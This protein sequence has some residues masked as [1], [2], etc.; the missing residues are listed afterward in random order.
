MVA[1]P[2]WRLTPPAD[3]GAYSPNP[4]EQSLSV[5]RWLRAEFGNLER[6]T[7]VFVIDV[8]DVGVHAK[9]GKA[10]MERHADLGSHPMMTTVRGN[11]DRRGVAMY[12]RAAMVVVAAIGS[13]GLHSAAIAQNARDPML[14][15]IAEPVAAATSPDSL[16]PEEKMQRRYPQWVRVGDLIGLQVLDDDD[17]TLGRVRTVVRTSGGKIQLIVPFGGFLGWRQRLVA[18]PIEVVAIAGRQI[19]ALDMT[20]AEFDAALAWNDPGSQ[21]ISPGER[22][23]IG[24]YRR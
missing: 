9:K 22:I 1:A 24:L 11:A 13:I 15:F 4:I 17:R 5:L 3:P 16:S 10:A 20:R 18:V 14:V 8:T 6:G 2:F 12:G 23:R 19:A 21:V 7:H